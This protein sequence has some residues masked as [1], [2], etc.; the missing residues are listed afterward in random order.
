MK[1]SD[2]L[3]LGNWLHSDWCQ[4]ETE[5]Q[6]RDRASTQFLI[7]KYGAEKSVA[8]LTGELNKTLNQIMADAWQALSKAKQKQ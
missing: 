3:T 1:S 8:E 4:G 5:E 2:E 6:E 7:D